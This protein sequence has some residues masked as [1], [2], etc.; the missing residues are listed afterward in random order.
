MANYKLSAKLVEEMIS[1]TGRMVNRRADNMEQAFPLTHDQIYAGCIP[2]EWKELLISMAEYGIGIAANHVI[3]LRVEHPSIIRVACINIKSTRNFLGFV[4]GK[5]VTFD[6]SKLTDKEISALAS[7]VNNAVQ[8]HRVGNLVKATVIEFLRNRAATTGHVIARWPA[9]T[10]L[11]ARLQEEIGNRWDSRTQVETRKVWR[12]KFA[13][14]PRNLKPYSW[15]N[16]DMVW[17]EKHRKAMAICD[18]VLLSASMLP[19]VVSTS[20]IKASV[21]SWVPLPT[22]LDKP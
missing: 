17:Y 15:S 1:V 10:M 21:T 12:E 6:T 18:E 7:W 14:P 2:A 8:E 5:Q 13:D 3:N 20:D 9:L 11:V 22:D 19:V 16:E 4:H